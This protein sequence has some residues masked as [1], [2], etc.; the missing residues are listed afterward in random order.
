MIHLNF[1]GESSRGLQ[2]LCLGSHSD[3]IEIGC[4]GTILRLSQQYPS[5]VF[6]WVVFTGCPTRKAEAQR[7]AELFVPSRALRGPILKTFSDGFMPFAAAEVKGFFEELKGTISPDLIFTH[8]RAD[9]HQD[10][11][12]IAELTWNTF[13]NHLILE[14]EIP[15]YD[16]DMGRPG[17]F[18]PLDS[19]TCN[20]K[21][22]YIIE[23]FQSQRDKQWFERETFSSLMRLRGMECNAS[24]G[25]AEAFYCRKLVL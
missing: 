24:S 3:D 20:R 18:V 12:L 2:I 19:E 4:G 22:D 21:I 23:S 7:A 17:V 25:Y 10:H 9:A 11:R 14:Y 13:R 8:N 15:K 6:H 16:G 1:N 5:A